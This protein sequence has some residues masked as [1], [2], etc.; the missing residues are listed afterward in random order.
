MKTPLVLATLLALAACGGTELAQEGGEPT[1]PP[2]N[3]PTE[4]GRDPIEAE[5]NRGP[6][7]LKYLASDKG[8]RAIPPNTAYYSIEFHTDG[9]ITGDMDCNKFNS[10]YSAGTNS[11]AI[12]DINEDAASCAEYHA[13]STQALRASLK[14]AET[15]AVQKEELIIVTENGQ[16]V[17]FEPL[18]SGCEGPIAVADG[19]GSNVYFINIKPEASERDI[20][21][22]LEASRSDFVL[23]E[24]GMCSRMFSASMNANTLSILRCRADIDHLSVSF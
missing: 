23:T 1:I 13:S 21:A 5:L 10:T 3:E 19:D 22:E 7:V 12:G 17:V 4:P 11:L 15:Y 24:H 14:T 2:P 18:H 8:I 20:L 16:Q 9:T 6:W